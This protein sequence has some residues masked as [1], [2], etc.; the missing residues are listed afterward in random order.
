MDHESLDELSSYGMIDDVQLI[1]YSF[2]A[3]AL[4]S[5]SAHFTDCG[6][7][8]SFVLSSVVLN[9]VD[10]ISPL[11]P[12]DGGIHGLVIA[13]AQTAFPVISSFLN[14]MNILNSEVGRMA[15][16]TSMIVVSFCYF[17]ILFLMLRPLVIWI[18]NRNPKGKPMTQNH[19]LSIICI[20]L[21][22]GFSAQV[23]GQPSFLVAF[24][25]GLI[26]PDGPPLGSVLAERIDTVGSA[27]IVPAYCTISGLKTNVPSLAGSKSASIEFII[28]AGYIGK[29]L[30]TILPSLHFK[31]GFR[32]SFALSLIMCCKGIIDLNI[33]NT[34]LTVKHNEGCVM[35]HSFTSIAPY[36]SMHDDICYMAMDS[37]S[38][39]VIVPFHKQWSINGNVTVCN[40]SI[41]TLNQ[42]VLNKAP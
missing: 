25:F 4:L 17:S 9:V 1:N 33:F 24:W 38:N 29:F 30:G 41:R 23:A 5:N 26:L 21:F 8:S 34:L 6:Y 10:I 35:L 28:I 18:S 20:L 37:E 15:L 22:V 31:I 16:S 11:G 13:S 19:F 36:A 27:L 39:I 42:K 14:E 7:L 40:A 12:Q 3:K 32:D 2:L